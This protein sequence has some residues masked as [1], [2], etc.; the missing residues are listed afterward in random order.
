MC[1]LELGCVRIEK[2]WPHLCEHPTCLQ[3]ARRPPFWNVGQHPARCSPVSRLRRVVRRPT[4]GGTLPSRGP[5]SRMSALRIA[6]AHAPQTTANDIGDATMA[7][8]EHRHEFLQRFGARP[9][10]TLGSAER[11]RARRTSGC[12][13]TAGTVELTVNLTPKLL[14][15][16]ADFLSPALLCLV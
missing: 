13:G 3:T 4:T 15:M 9:A 6:S 12:G 2:N 1:A 14:K 10:A 8:L 5:L 11:W 16:Q 7:V